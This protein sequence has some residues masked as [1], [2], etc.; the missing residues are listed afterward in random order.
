M[1]L[2]DRVATLLSVDAPLRPLLERG[3]FPFS[4]PFVWDV[5][6]FANEEILYKCV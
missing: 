5:Y 4:M 3:D 2:C 1:D 6:T